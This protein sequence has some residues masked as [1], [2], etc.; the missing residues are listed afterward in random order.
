MCVRLRLP[1]VFGSKLIWQCL[2][3]LTKLVQ[4]ELLQSKKIKHWKMLKTFTSKRKNKDCKKAFYSTAL[5]AQQ[6]S[7]I[8]ERRLLL[9]G[10]MSSY[11]A[12]TK[13]F[14]RIPLVTKN[15]S[16]GFLG[17]CQSKIFFTFKYVVKK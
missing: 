7:E 2:Q 16:A 4:S 13:F 10:K 3:T 17:V 14:V 12:S 15:G 1:I 11:Q 5:F 9:K 6:I 8:Q